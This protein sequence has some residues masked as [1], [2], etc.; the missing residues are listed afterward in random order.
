MTPPE[1]ECDLVMKG[2][3]TSGVV[4]P[5]AIRK[6]AGAY[7]FRNVGGASAGA[8]A[9]VAAA[10][11]E[12]RR[13][14]GVD[15]AFDVLGEVGR[16]ISAQGFVL[17]LFQPTAEARPPFDIALRLVTS[18]SSGPRRFL[19]A[20][21]SILRVRGRFLAV[22]VA[23]VLL[24]VA[25]VVL[26]MWAL[27]SGGP[28]ALEVAAAILLALA[29]IPVAAL[30]VGA[31]TLVA[32]TRFVVGIDRALKATW[33][34][35]CT[36][37]TEEGRPD[38]SGLTDWLHGT[39]QRCA[40]LPADEPLTF[41]KLRGDDDKNPVVNLQLITTDLSSAR[42]VTLPLPEPAEEEPR[43]YLFDPQEWTKLFPDPIVDHLV[44]V[45]KAEGRSDKA[46]GRDLY[47]V[48]GL[49]LPVVV[50]ARLSLSFPILL[51]TVPFWRA[52]GPNGTFVQ[53]TMSDGGIS[54]N[55]PI[56]YFDSLFPGRPTFGLDLQPWRVPT[57]KPVEMS[58]RLRR[59]GFS[60]ITTVG[61]FFTRILNAARN[62]RDNM[63]AELPG[64][65]DRICQI[66][67]SAEEG[68]LNLDMPAEIVDRLVERGELAG[69]TILDGES[70]DWDRHRITRFWT[71]MQ[72]LQQ[73]L[74]PQGLGRPGVYSGEH[75]GRIAFKTVVERWQADGKSPEPPPLAWWAPALLA[76]DAAFGLAEE[77]ADFDAD[78][79]KPTPTL[80]IV[81]RA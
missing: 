70:F 41:R 25:T 66:R 53:H 46:R 49:D 17:S 35:M 73:S 20:V 33:F 31:A 42:P 64:Y 9:A 67:L 36:G 23:A 44:E 65:R 29:A 75:Q 6:I 80:R 10:G 32:L 1:R 57:Q 26:G 55:F 52:D 2:G 5:G 37:R 24:W 62:W 14:R 27:L 60:E 68:G 78:A 72:M 11:C 21:V 54:S 59:P 19:E 74:G 34:G 18:T 4:Y 16:E 43:V 38:G 76:S 28:G 8:I 56:H 15:D 61:D 7:R 48:P 39:I 71:M 45:S 51:A 13:S 58:G 77:W 30:L 63:Q 12:F 81:P 40:G 22:A 50:A 47:P 69:D 79:P 3:I